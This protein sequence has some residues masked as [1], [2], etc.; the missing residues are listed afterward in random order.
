MALDPGGTTMPRIAAL[1]MLRSTIAGE[2]R[3]KRRI[4]LALLSEFSMEM[5]DKISLRLF[6]F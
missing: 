6:G 2:G 5:F 3:G 1:H 4:A